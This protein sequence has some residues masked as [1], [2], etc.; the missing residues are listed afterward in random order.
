MK[1]ITITGW[2]KGMAKISLCKTIRRETGNSLP[3]GKAVV[4]S[5]LS[6]G[7]FSFSVAEEDVQA[8]SEELDAI[9]VTYEIE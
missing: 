1:T 6:G 4:D 5:I 3:E 9:K 8:I 2:K 7:S